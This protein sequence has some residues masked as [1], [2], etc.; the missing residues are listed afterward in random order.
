MCVNYLYLAHSQM[1]N[2][3]KYVRSCGTHMIFPKKKFVQKYFSCRNR[4]CR[5][6]AHTLSHYTFLRGYYMV[7]Y[8]CKVSRSY[9]KWKWSSTEVKFSARKC[10]EIFQAFHVE[11]SKILAVCLFVLEI[12]GKYLFFFT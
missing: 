9:V 11:K 5:L 6:C 10:V 8:H 3:T 12:P 4:M 2:E 7:L 1:I